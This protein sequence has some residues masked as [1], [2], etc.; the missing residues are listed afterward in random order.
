[1][2]YFA[3]FELAPKDKETMLKSV[4]KEASRDAMANLVYLDPSLANEKKFKRKHP[5]MTDSEMNVYLEAHSRAKLD[6][7]KCEPRVHKLCSDVIKNKLDE[8]KFPFMG[9]RP[10]KKKKEDEETKGFDLNDMKNKP[11]VFVFIAGGLSHHEIVSL[12]RLQISSN[13]RIVPG[14]DQIYSPSEYLGYLETLA[15][16]E[17][18]QQF[19]D[20]IMQ[21]GKF[22]NTEPLN[23]ESMLGDENLLNVTL[24]FD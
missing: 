10:S 16:T 24:D 9:E 5:E 14:A 17:T 11:K 12:E 23:I 4:Q 6:I 20:E 13:T 19:K 18:L 15:K 22:E 1:M 8:E 2:I 7:L 3:C 21:R